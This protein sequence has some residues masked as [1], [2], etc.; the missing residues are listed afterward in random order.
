MSSNTP[1]Q[2][3]TFPQKP[4][5][6]VLLCANL[7]CTWGDCDFESKY[8]EMMR[9]HIIEHHLPTFQPVNVYPCQ[10]ADC[11]QYF[12]TIV[13]MAKHVDEVHLAPPVEKDEFDRKFE[14]I[15][16]REKVKIL[17]E[18]NKKLHDEIQKLQRQN[19]DLAT[20][21][22]IAKVNFQQTQDEINFVWDIGK[23][24]QQQNR[25]TDNAATLKLLD[26]R[27]GGSRSFEKMTSGKRNLQNS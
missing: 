4:I 20:D 5:I 27:F 19:I 18:E 1:I 8:F 17:D 16:V 3:Q 7:K 14:G 25:E 12:G 2:N 23:I 10:W 9:Q 15:S 21:H 22:K 11:K 13:E 24:H 6:P 26:K